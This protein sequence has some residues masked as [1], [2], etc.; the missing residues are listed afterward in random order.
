M[1]YWEAIQRF[2]YFI[3]LDNRYDYY[4]QLIKNLSLSREGMV[5]LQNVLIKNL[6]KHA[7]SESPYY[8][9]LF[10]KLNIKPHEINNQ[11]DLNRLPPLTKKDIKENLDKLKTKDKFGRQLKEV[12]SGGSTGNQAIIFKSRYFEEVSRAAFLRNNTL[13]GW[14]PG[15]K[16][17]WLWGAP[18][19]HQRVSGSLKSKIGIFINRRLLFNAY[20]FNPEQ[21]TDLVDKIKNYRPKVLYGYASLILSFSE[22]LIKNA[23]HLDSIERVVTTTETLRGREVIEKAFFCNV[24]DQYGCREVLAVGIEVYKENM[25]VADDVVALNYLEDDSV[26]ITA[27]HSF[28][29]PLIN[30]QVGDIIKKTN[31]AEF[32]KHLPFSTMRIKIG[33]ET[34]NFKNIKGETISSSALSVYIST[35][36]LPFKE[37][38]VL[39][40]AHDLFVISYIPDMPNLNEELCLNTLYKIFREYFGDKIKIDLKLVD[41]L[42]VEKSGKK[43]LFKR[44]FD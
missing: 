38:Q 3:Q 26:L 2:S 44:L 9:D 31:N 35:F 15:D 1:N 28:G 30:Y 22:Y 42:S 27:L 19:E 23:I 16:S 11:F 8:H 37:Y 41:Q 17:L 12:T 5:D 18:Y 20:K 6:V 4:D 13:C 29:F 25:V 10:K 36:K 34:D 39:Q 24:H 14:Q 7:Y 32:D 33:R 40:K 21:F 43:L